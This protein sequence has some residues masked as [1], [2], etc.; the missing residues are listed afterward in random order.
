[1]FNISKHAR[2]S[3]ATL[4][5]ISLSQFASAAIITGITPF[6]GIYS[7]AG[8]SVAT[9]DP[10]NDDVAGANNNVLSILQKHYTAVGTV[11]IVL[12]LVDNAIGIGGS[13][14]TEYKVVENVQ[15]STGVDWFGYRILLGYGTGGSF[16]LS[17]PGDGLDFDTPHENSPIN[18][19]PGPAD[20]TTIT[21]PNE[22]T[23]EATDGTLL[24]G[25]FSG[26]DFVFHI[27]VPN[28]MTEFTLRQEPIITV[29]EPSSTALLGLGSLALVLR[30][31]R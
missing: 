16:T 6:P 18:F 25:Q 31:R 3:A 5:S 29:P 2:I 10:G 14:T 21:R 9:P 27:D 13:T 8:Q 24:N 26:T 19:S 20:F 7:I 23:L 12:S 28:G 15:N 30:R 11:D 17:S 1:M 4:A 22:D